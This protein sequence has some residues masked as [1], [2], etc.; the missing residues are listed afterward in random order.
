[1]CKLAVRRHLQHGPIKSNQLWKQEVIFKARI[2]SKNYSLKGTK[3]IFFVNAEFILFYLCLHV[4]NNIVTL[5][6]DRE[7]SHYANLADVISSFSQM[8][9]LSFI[10]SATL[11]VGFFCEIQV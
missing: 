8:L 11:Y 7:I 4:W 2:T 9:L 10:N 5:Y 6:N 1:M 3:D